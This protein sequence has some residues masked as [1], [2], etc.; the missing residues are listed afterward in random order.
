MSSSQ[1][2]DNHTK[3][4]PAYHGFVFPVLAINWFW[5]WYRLW[6][7]PG[8]DP[9]IGVL[10]AS[11]LIGLALYARLFA[12]RVQDRVIRLEMRLRLARCLPAAA[13]PDVDRFTMSQLIALRFA[14]D[15][16][17]PE[18]AARVLE[19]NLHDR[20][21]IKKRIRNWQADHHRA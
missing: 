10:V 1:S 5:S 18:L 16:E 12:L 3:L 21:E 8:I 13:Q 17:L 9:V 20:R 15:E 4:V 11:A 6:S 2:F 14:S 7:A 19:E